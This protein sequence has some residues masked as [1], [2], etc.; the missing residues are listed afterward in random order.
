MALSQSASAT[1]QT[2]LKKQ[3]VINASKDRSRIA[4]VENDELVELYVENPDNVR[5]IGNVYLGQ[6]QKVMPAI[7]AAF[8]DV[9]P[10]PLRGTGPGAA[11][12]PGAGD[13]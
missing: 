6:I 5:T 9:G 1:P 8:V 10:L 13:P 3:I 4:I 12:G 7:R 2:P 11:A